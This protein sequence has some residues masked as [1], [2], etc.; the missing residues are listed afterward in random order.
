MGTGG[1]NIGDQT[2]NQ[3]GDQTG[4]K[5]GSNQGSKQGS[6]QGTRQGTRQGDQTREQTGEQTG[7]QTVDQ[8]YMSLNANSYIS[9]YWSITS[10]LR[11][12]RR[13]TKKRALI[14]IGLA[15]LASST[16]VVPVLGWHYFE[17][18]GVRQNTVGS[19]I[20]CLYSTF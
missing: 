16:W 3:T 13:R 10:P 19:E 6:K 11:Y 7:D 17:F 9:R 4:E 18:G 12:L 14:M 1:R 15:W 20:H 5:Q 2:G 8:T